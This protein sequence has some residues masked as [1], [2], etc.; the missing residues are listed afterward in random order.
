MKHKTVEQLL[1][2]GSRGIVGI[3]EVLS[4]STGYDSKEPAADPGPLPDWVFGEPMP[5]AEKLKL[6]DMMLNRWA[7]YKAAVQQERDA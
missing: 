7:R 6:A 2:P 1:G 4:I 5:K 3:D